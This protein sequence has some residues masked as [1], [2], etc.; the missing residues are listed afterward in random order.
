MYVV[1]TLMKGQE[2]VTATGR[3]Q[4]CF[5]FVSWWFLQVCFS[6]HSDFWNGSGIFLFIFLINYFS[7]TKTPV[8]FS[9]PKK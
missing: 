9:S 2:C 3:V 5:F 8:S 4:V 1:S 6:F 7:I